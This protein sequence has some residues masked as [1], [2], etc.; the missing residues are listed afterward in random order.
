[1]LGAPGLLLGAVAGALLWRT[2]HLAGAL[3]GAIAGFI[4][5]LTGWML[6]HDV[7]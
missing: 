2:R 1:M 3:L 5:W 7:I 6:L 4:A